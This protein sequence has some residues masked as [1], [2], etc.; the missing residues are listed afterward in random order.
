MKGSNLSIDE[1][2]GTGF[3]SMQQLTRLPLS[4]L[5]IDQTFVTGACKQ[6]VLAAL[7]E[8]SVAMA[9]RLKLEDGRRR[10]RNQ[11]RLG[12]RRQARGR[13]VA[14]GYFIA[15]PM[16]GGEIADW[17][18]AWLG[19][20]RGGDASAPR[21]GRPA[22]SSASPM[23]DGDFSYSEREGRSGIASTSARDA[24]P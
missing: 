16:P 24:S 8:T 3:S 19:A 4:E 12:C 10:R 20:R 15:K 22:S 14:Q 9:R 23:A 2:H 7:I 11:R 6:E 18:S 1:F 5:K 13:D 17:S 21:P